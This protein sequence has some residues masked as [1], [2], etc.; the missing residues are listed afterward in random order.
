MS[1]FKAFLEGLKPSG[2]HCLV[3]EV[4]FGN[5]DFVITDH[6]NVI[7]IRTDDVLWHKERLLNIGIKQLLADGYRKIAWLDG[8]ITFAEDDW[9]LEVANRLEH[10]N[11]CQVFET[12]AVQAYESG[13]PMVAPSSVKYFRDFDRLYMQPSRRG[14]SLLKG[15]LLGGQSGFG[16]A[17]R[18]EVFEKSLLFEN[19]VVGGGD[20][21]MYISSLASD[22][23]DERFL[24]LTQSKFACKHCGHKNRSEIYREQFHNW[25]QQWKA[26]VDGKVDYARLQISDMFHG[27]RSDRGYMTRHDI[28]YRHN[29]DPSVDLI[30]DGDGC[31]SWAEG[32]D[33]LKAEVEGYFMSRR[34]D[35]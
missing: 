23:S 7:Q 19:A 8:D 25:A 20:K 12:I 31:L 15:R 3:V 14:P 33:Q 17:V 18:A 34:E 27:K 24:S 29:Y 1:N 30:S 10:A 22:F 6:E 28:L 21:L 35:V 2:V 5:N 9:P 26:A 16:W 4:A 11:L 13:P 32:R